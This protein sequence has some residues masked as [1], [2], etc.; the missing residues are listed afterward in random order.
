MSTITLEEVKAEHARLADM[1][2]TLE[3]QSPQELL[4]RLP[5]VEIP[6]KPGEL[7]AGVM[8]DDDGRRLSHHLVLLPQR[9][10]ELT[11][12]QAVEWAESAGGELPTRREQSLLFANLK[13]HFEKAWYWS[14]WSCSGVPWPGPHVIATML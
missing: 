4:L 5:E 3:R 9:A 14:E 7:Y 1:I 6:L 10:N 11:W 13:Q 8:L 12:D 2:A